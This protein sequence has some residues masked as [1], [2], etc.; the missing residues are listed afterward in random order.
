[1]QEPQIDD[2]APQPSTEVSPPKKPR[3]WLTA[4]FNMASGAA[5]SLAI[6]TT[7]VACTSTV[8]APAVSIGIAAVAAG[9]A[10]SYVRHYFENRSLVKS[11]QEP[12]KFT[13]KKAA[14]GGAFG[15]LGAGVASVGADAL[16]HFAP[17][18]ISDL[19]S[20]FGFAPA[21]ACPDQAPVAPVVTAEPAI[22]EPV[23]A[24][25]VVPAVA[26]CPPSPLDCV[27]EIVKADGGSTKV[28]EALARAAS[29]SA[30]VS[31]QGTKD[32]GYFLMNGLE[33][34]PKD[35]CLAVKLLKEAAECGNIQ[36][37]IDL[38]YLEFHGNAAAGVD[39]NP[40]EALEKMKGIDTAKARL[41]VAQWTGEAPVVEA[42]APAPVAAAPTVSSSFTPAATM[43]PTVTLP[44]IEP[45][46]TVD[47]TAAQT[48][49]EASTQT[50]VASAPVGATVQ[51]GPG[52]DCTAIIRGGSSD[53]DFVCNIPVEDENF[54]VG[55]KV[56]IQRP[57]MLQLIR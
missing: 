10:S 33:G 7:L 8:L 39:A 4:A 54:S 11:G 26:P 13:F 37:K 41:F 27:Q 51:S 34:L 2:Q 56:I 12:V 18:F 20:F 24:A 40:T 30:R 5:V 38:A 1:M 44:A 16:H 6:K 42:P 15:L 48:T 21:A 19:K 23:A 14:F 17:D 22:V 25:D 35:P 29:T 57:A 49:V 28:Q 31:A 53:I 47:L 36:A 9:V 55:D 52:M 46:A 3:K 43:Q 50:T 45:V 32:L